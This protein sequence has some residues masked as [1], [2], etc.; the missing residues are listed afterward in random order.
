MANLIFLTLKLERLPENDTV[1]LERIYLDP[2]DSDILLNE[3]TTIDGY[4]TEPWTVTREYERNRNPIWA[5]FDCQTDNRYI[6]VGDDFYILNWKRTM[7]LPTR[8][9]QSPPPFLQQ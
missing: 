1:T 6:L 2:K 9:G 4:L 5:D 3:L 7:L 8:E